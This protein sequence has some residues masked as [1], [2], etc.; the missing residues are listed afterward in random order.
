MQLKYYVSHE[1]KQ[2]GPY[3]IDEIVSFVSQGTLSPLDYIY[4]EKKSDWIIFLDYEELSEKVKSLK[5]KAPPRFEEPNVQEQIVKKPSYQDNV[6]SVAKGPAQQEWF[7]LKGDNKFGPFTYTDVVKML[8][9]GVVFEFDFA[10][11]AGIDGWRRL[12]E[13]EE[14]DKDHMKKLKDTASLGISEVFFRRRYKRVK[15]GGTILIHDNKKVW[16]GKGVEISEGGAGVVMENSMVLPGQ[17]LYLHFKPGDGV[18]PFNAICEVVSKQFVNKVEGP[19]ASMKYGLKFKTVSTETQKLI[20]DY[21]KKA[22]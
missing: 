5:P 6:P 15:Y 16:K 10:W 13:I 17:E 1:T 2:M 8:Q 21:M 9:Q 12:A 18:P 14:F 20:K 19:N 7:V 4:D 22:A 11:H 3:T